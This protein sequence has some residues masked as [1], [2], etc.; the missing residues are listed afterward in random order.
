[1]PE[2]HHPFAIGA[3]EGSF[4]PVPDESA[5]EGLEADRSSE[6]AVLENSAIDVRRVDLELCLARYDAAL[7]GQ[8]HARRLASPSVR[9]RG[10]FPLA[11]IDTIGAGIA[12]GRQEQQGG[13]RRDTAQAFHRA[14]ATLG[15]HPL[16]VDPSSNRNAL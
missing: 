8:R 1:M 2:Q 9:G 11:V 16:Q 12:D 13:D 4:E 7:N 15:A 3:L 6:R 10:A 5:G 14:L